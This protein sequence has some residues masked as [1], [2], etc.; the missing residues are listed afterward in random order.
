MSPGVALSKIEQNL[1]KQIK[2]RFS[3]PALLGKLIFLNSMSYLK[4][5]KVHTNFERVKKTNVYKK[6]GARGDKKVIFC[7]REGDL[8]HL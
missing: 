1:I 2:L 8:L 4:T 5:N 6:K 3:Y 7:D